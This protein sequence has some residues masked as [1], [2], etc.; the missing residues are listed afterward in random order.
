[1]T[2]KIRTGNKI[3]LEFCGI[4]AAPPPHITESIN[5]LTKRWKPG[6]FQDLE[7]KILSRW[8]ADKKSRQNQK[9][10]KMERVL[11]ERESERERKWKWREKAWFFGLSC[12][13]LKRKPLRDGVGRTWSKCHVCH[14]R[15]HSVLCSEHQLL[16]FMAFKGK[17]K[18]PGVYWRCHSCRRVAG[19]RRPATFTA[20]FLH[21]SFSPYSS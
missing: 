12:K 7:S 20:I 5:R 10:I 3:S 13:K 2:S 4:A 19:A 8:K 15:H 18:C 1:M 21:F 14:Y 11:S 16:Q 17:Q 9:E 6:R